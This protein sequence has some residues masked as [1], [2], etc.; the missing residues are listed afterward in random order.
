MARFNESINFY[1]LKEVGF[2]G[3]IFTWLYQRRDGMQIRERLDRALASLDWHSLF[4]SA[5]VFHNT[6][7]VSDHNPLVL[8]FFLVQKR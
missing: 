6:S 4:P 1:G 3:P 2:V 7:S 8:H 5:K